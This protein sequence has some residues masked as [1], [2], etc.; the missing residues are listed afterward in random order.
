MSV[1]IRHIKIS[2]YFDMDG[3]DRCVPSHNIR[4]AQFEH[5]AIDKAYYMAQIWSI[6]THAFTWT[7]VERIPLHTRKHSTN[8]L[9]AFC[10]VYPVQLTN[11]QVMFMHTTEWRLLYWFPHFFFIFYFF[12][13]ILFFSAF[14]MLTL[15]LLWC[16]LL[17]WWLC[18]VKIGA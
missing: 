15:L 12:L 17:S 10:F 6:H 7:F 9:S 18:E 14:E 13:N 5:S 2:I 4:S 8:F 11:E 1:N 16:V 3:M